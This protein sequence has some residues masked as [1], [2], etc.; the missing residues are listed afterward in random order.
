MLTMAWHNASSADQLHRLEHAPDHPHHPDADDQ[1]GDL[2]NH[3]VNQAVQ[4]Q[5]SDRPLSQIGE[6][7]ARAAAVTPVMLM[8]RW[9]GSNSER[10][11]RQE[12]CDGG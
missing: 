11:W 12:F 6:D 5:F 8:G 10:Q 4:A 1:R 2:G 3:V 7:H 9:T